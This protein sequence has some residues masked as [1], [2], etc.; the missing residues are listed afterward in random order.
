MSYIF[1]SIFFSVATP[2]HGGHLA[3]YYYQLDGK[4]LKL[5]FVIEKAELTGFEFEDNCDIRNKT[6]LCAARYLNKQLSIKINGKKIEMELQS[7]YTERDHF[8][9]RLSSEFNGASINEIV[10]QNQC[11][12]EFD[13]DFKNRIILD[14]GRFQKSYLLNRERDKINLK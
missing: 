9:V 10:I 14:V 5:K 7:S 8:I 4:S 3:E 13:P 12:Y 6:A 11:F 1:I 2:F